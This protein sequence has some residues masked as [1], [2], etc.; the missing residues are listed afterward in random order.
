MQQVGLR[1]ALRTAITYLS[2]DVEDMGPKSMRGYGSL[3][4]AAAEELTDI[5]RELNRLLERTSEFLVQSTG[6]QH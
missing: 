6:K 4:E 3:D 2:A 5:Q 1:W